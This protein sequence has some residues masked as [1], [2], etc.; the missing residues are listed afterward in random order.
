M[1]VAIIFSSTEIYI[2]VKPLLVWNEN[3]TAGFDFVL[4]E[5][6]GSYRKLAVAN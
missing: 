1:E 2:G 6:I 4:R 3:C 5:W